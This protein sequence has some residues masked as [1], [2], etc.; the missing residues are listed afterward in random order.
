MSRGV[1]SVLVG[2]RLFRGIRTRRRGRRVK[3]GHCS[4]G[5]TISSI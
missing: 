5:I 2:C 1:L 3:M 4:M